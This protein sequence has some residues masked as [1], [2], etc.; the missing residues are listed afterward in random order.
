MKQKILF[1]ATCLLLLVGGALLA[2]RVY[3]W[4]VREVWNVDQNKSTIKNNVTSNTYTRQEWTNVNSNYATT[5]FET[6]FH[7]F[8]ARRQVSLSYWVFRATVTITPNPY[9]VQKWYVWDRYKRKY[10]FN[11]STQFSVYMAANA[12][13]TTP[14]DRYAAMRSSFSVEGT[15]FELP[16]RDY[17]TVT[18]GKIKGG[19]GRIRYQDTRN[20]KMRFIGSG[21]A[22]RLFIKGPR[23]SGA[24]YWYAYN[25][26]YSD[27]P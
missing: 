12:T 18:V 11:T 25:K 13:T 2:Q 16:G 5:N 7:E 21:A 23:G 17:R 3:Q 1:F 8:D 10:L 20:F 27:K 24:Y 4:Q 15:G 6:F 19:R 26:H 14:N 22:P 9:W